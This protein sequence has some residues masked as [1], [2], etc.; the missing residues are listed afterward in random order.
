MTAS[1]AAVAA[2]LAALAAARPASAHG[3]GDRYDLP[4]PLS[5]W[6]AGAAIAVVLSFVVIGVCVRGAATAGH[7][8][9]LNLLRWRMGRLLVDR[10]VWL[11][12]QAVSVAL[13]VLIVA[14]GVIGTQNPMRNLAPTAIWVVWWVGLA[15]LSALVGDVWQILNPWSALFTLVERS[16]R[17]LL[18]R[19]PSSPIPAPWGSG[20]RSCSSA[21]SRGSSSSSTGARCPPSS[22][23]SRS[24]TR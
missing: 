20:P 14:A 21:P 4:V 11:A 5:L 6:V 9:R 1:R 17:D 24:G 19:S 10:R 23:C 15:Y 2:L 18:T 22:R 13:L 7:Y 8:P 16:E 3:F 12:G